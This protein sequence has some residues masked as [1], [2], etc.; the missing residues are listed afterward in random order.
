MSRLFRNNPMG[1]RPHSIP[2][3]FRYDEFDVAY[4]MNNMGF[5]DDRDYGPPESGKNLRIVM[6]GDSMVEGFGV[7]L[8]QTLS[9]LLECRLREAGYAVE[10]L[11]CSWGGSGPVQ[12]DKVLRFILDAEL[13]PDL[14][15]YNLFTFN[16]IAM[17]GRSV[18]DTF[19]DGDGGGDKAGEG[20]RKR[21][22]RTTAVR[23]GYRLAWRLRRNFGFLFAQRRR[24]ARLARAKGYRVDFSNAPYRSADIAVFGFPKACCHVST[25]RRGSCWKGISAGRCIR[26][27]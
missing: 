25:D 27:W 5:R 17:L 1:V 16:N 15:V 10:V 7:P 26:T 23:A 8:S 3:R 11:N 12:W 18:Y 21:L 4:R 19:F 6:I 20:L 13:N 24:Y 2:Y 9:K 22:G 14:V